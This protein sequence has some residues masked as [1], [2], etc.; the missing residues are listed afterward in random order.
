LLAANSPRPREIADFDLGGAAFSVIATGR[1]AAADTSRAS[2]A[3]EEAME[4]AK[5]MPGY[6]QPAF[7]T[8]DLQLAF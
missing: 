8:V 2:D 4:M 3:L 5:V 1:F 6:P 7:V